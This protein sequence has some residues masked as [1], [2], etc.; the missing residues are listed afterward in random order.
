MQ[1]AEAR[2]TDLHD[3][4]EIGL[5]GECQRS[6]RRQRDRDLRRTDGLKDR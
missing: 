6:A 4:R 3:G 1:V 5:A 2:R